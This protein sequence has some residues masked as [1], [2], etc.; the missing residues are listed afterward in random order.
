M[1]RGR[2]CILDNVIYKHN[3]FLSN[4]SEV[5]EAL[6]NCKIKPQEEAQNEEI[7]QTEAAVKCTNQ[8]SSEEESV[9]K[10]TGESFF[11]FLLFLTAFKLYKS[12]DPPCTPLSPPLPLGAYP[13]HPVRIPLTSHLPQPV[14]DHPAL[15]MMPRRRHGGSTWDTTILRRRLPIVAS[16]C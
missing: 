11:C 15:Q 3:N 4:T 12:F 6:N 8:A 14:L 1:C 13:S 16:L 2:G 5:E 10:T 7:I 9:E